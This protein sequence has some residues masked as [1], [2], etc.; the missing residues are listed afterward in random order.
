MWRQKLPAIQA[1]QVADDVAF[2]K[3][4]YVPAQASDDDEEYAYVTAFR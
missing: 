3:A 1:E 4:E 2:V